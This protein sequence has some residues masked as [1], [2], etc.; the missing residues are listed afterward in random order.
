MSLLG[1][2]TRDA[3]LGLSAQAQYP[4]VFDKHIRLRDRPAD[5]CSVLH[6][7]C[8]KVDRDTDVQAGKDARIQRFD[9]YR[10]TVGTELHLSSPLGLG[11]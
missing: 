9:Q 3:K 8:S 2:R 1:Q 6:S 5:H 4:A 7:Q 11:H 10:D